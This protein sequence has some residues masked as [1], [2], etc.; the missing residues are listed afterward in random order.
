MVLELLTGD[1]MP[2]NLPEEGCLLYCCSNKVEFVKQMTLF[3]KWGPHRVGL[4]GP[5]ESPVFVAPHPATR[6]RPA[7]GAGIGGGCCW[8]MAMLLLRHR[9]H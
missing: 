1:P 7:P 8:V 9:R 4:E 5:Q 6:V 3:D 2:A